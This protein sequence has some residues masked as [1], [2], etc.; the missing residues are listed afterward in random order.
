MILT[1]NDFSPN[2]FHSLR[3]IGNEDDEGQQDIR[4]GNKW[5]HISVTLLSLVTENLRLILDLVHLLEILFQNNDNILH[6]L[7]A[8]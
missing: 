2:P 1:T 3:D 7:L 8:V 5:V 4:L 6:R